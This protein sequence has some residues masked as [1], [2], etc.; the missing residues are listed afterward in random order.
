[1]TSFP[2]DVYEAALK[3]EPNF[4]LSTLRVPLLQIQS[5]Q[6]LSSWV[7]RPHQQQRFGN[8]SYLKETQDLPPST[9]VITL[10]QHN[11]KVKSIVMQTL[12][13][14]PPSSSTAPMDLWTS[15]T[16][17][18]KHSA[19]SFVKLHPKRDFFKEYVVCQGIRIIPLNHY[20]MFIEAPRL[21]EDDSVHIR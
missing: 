12:I 9:R 6:F 10:L 5:S 14:W 21:I 3:L 17:S 1:M 15:L 11:G 18:H 19:I 13:K 16:V 20:E 2:A 8:L 4:W 7:N